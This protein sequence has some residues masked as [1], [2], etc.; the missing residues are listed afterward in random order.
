MPIP[1]LRVLVAEDAR[2]QRSIVVEM[3][4]SLGLHSI[5]EAS[6]GVEALDMIRHANPPINILFCDLKMPQMDGMELLRH[7]GTEIRHVEVVILSAMDKK[8][9][10]VV[11][12]VSSLYEIKLLGALEKPL[13]LQKLK[14]I[15]SKSGKA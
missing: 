11:N 7:L 8:L 15:L 6:N 9:L 4:R 3:L 12:K 2:L 5:S 14:Q 13:S 10:A 1:D